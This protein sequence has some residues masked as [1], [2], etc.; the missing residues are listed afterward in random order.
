VAWA[1]DKLYL[2]DPEFKS[3]TAMALEVVSGGTLVAASGAANPLVSGVAEWGDLKVVKAVTLAKPELCIGIAMQ[4]TA[5]SG[6]VAIITDG[7]IIMNAGSDALANGVTAGTAV[8]ASILGTAGVDGIIDAASYD[9]LSGATSVI[10]RAWT[11]AGT[12]SAV[13]M[14]LRA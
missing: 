3:Y 7:F 6:A 11:T 13:F 12:G 14:R 5:I 1:Y 10:G 2:K 8:R 9:A 4:N